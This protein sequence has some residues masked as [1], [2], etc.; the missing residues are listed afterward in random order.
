MWSL[1]V[2]R[3]SREGEGCMCGI[4]GVIGKTNVVPQLLTGLRNLEYRGYDSCGVAVIAD[5][6]IHLRKNV[7]AVEEVEQK[8]QFQELEGFIGLAHTRW[9]THGGVTR[10]NA[11]PHLSCS[12][13][14][15]LVHNGIIDNY[16]PIKAWLKERGHQ[17]LSQTDT[18][19]IVHLIEEYFRESGEIEPAFR[20]A[21]ARL[22]GS[23]AL[24]LISTHDPHTLFCARQESPLIIG[25]GNGN[26]YL[27]SDMNAFVE[28]TREVICL[29][30]GEYAVVRRD[31]VTIRQMQTGKRVV[32][33]CEQMPDEGYT[34]NDKG[35]YQHFMLKEIA[36]EPEVVQKALEIEDEA[37]IRLARTVA[38]S[39]HVYLTGIGTAFYVTLIAQHYFAR[40]ADRYIPALSS[41]EFPFLAQV[42]RGSTV[43]A[44]SQSGET[45]DTLRALRYAKERGATT[46]AVVNVPSS[47]MV[48]EVDQAIL[49]GAGPEICVLSTKS[50]VSQVIILLRV[51]LE[52]AVLEGKLEARMK[53]QYEQELAS[54]PALLT[55][56]I[57]SLPAQVRVPAYEYA[58]V[59]NWF[60]IGRGVYSAVALESALKFK[61]SSYLHAEGM[62]GG[63]LKHGTI[64]LIDETTS[65][66]AFVPPPE[67]KELFAL[68]LSSIQE[69]KARG[70]FVLGIHQEGDGS[71][72]KFFDAE[73]VL[74]AVSPLVAPVVA[75]TA[76]QILAY[77][78]A[79]ALGRSID[80]PRALAKSVTV[81]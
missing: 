17:F 65:T 24:A 47:S 1:L 12:G 71:E 40:L 74:P 15:A 52:L 55:D 81:T 51:A 61:E 22:E 35:K 13:D 58:K 14:F 50:T 45:I 33:A 26:M 27:G 72:E 42:G 25:V 66:A 63:F 37:I 78:T 3:A 21:L 39:A 38:Q 5:G 64:A 7:G 68:T 77:Y 32:R 11:H 34:I 69:I 60:F 18:E 29:E 43:I 67:E 36:E 44:V 23:F 76:G 56:L 54:L 6:T 16:R 53:E 70:G 10:A 80:K 28:Y 8:E 48:R 30:D 31:G 73:I 79:L 4:C 75:L 19:V 49:Q 62:S 41:D 20:K 46:A 59:H 57:A 9:A 2:R